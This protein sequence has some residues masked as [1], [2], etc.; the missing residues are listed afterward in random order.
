[1]SKAQLPTKVERLEDKYKGI[2]VSHLWHNNSD[3]SLK[4]VGKEKVLELYGRLPT[5][6]QHCRKIGITNEGFVAYRNPNGDVVFF[7]IY[8][9]PSKVKPSE[10]TWYVERGATEERSML[11]HPVG[12]SWYKSP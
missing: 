6:F 5:T 4:T 9:M 3:I 11:D 1:M 12:H 2:T 10:K 7:P 8:V